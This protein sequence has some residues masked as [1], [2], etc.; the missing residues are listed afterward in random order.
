MFFGEG[1]WTQIFRHLGQNSYDYNN[2][3]FQNPMLE[4][5]VINV[6]GTYVI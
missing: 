4:F 1:I 6:I 5:V 2:V 3:H